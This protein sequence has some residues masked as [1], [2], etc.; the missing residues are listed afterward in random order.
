M[1]SFLFVRSFHELLILANKTT[2]VSSPDTYQSI[3]KTA[4]GLY[5]EK[6]SKFLAF[7][8]PVKSAEQAKTKIQELRETHPKAVHVCFAWRIGTEQALE[9]F[10]DDGEPNNSA[11]K[12]IFGQINAFELT[13]ILLAVVRY[14]GGTKL[15]V[16]GLITAYKTA[17]KT[18]LDAAEIIEQIESVEAIIRFDPKNTG[19]LMSRLNKEQINIEDHTADANGHF[20]KVSLPKSEADKFINNLAAFPYYKIETTK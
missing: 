3:K 10:S 20:V 11:G 17:A 18:A 7:A 6:G 9:R 2:A 1:I 8:I 14:Y 4:E 19:D 13:N 15:G 16:G 12:P 5:K